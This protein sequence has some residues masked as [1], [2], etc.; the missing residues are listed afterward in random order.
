MSKKLILCDLCTKEN[1]YDYQCT[2]LTSDDYDEL[3]DYCSGCSHRCFQ[4]VE[5]EEGG[6]KC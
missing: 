5:I 3:I 2:K 4:Y 1:G 6:D